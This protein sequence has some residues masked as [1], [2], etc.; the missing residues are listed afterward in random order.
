MLL[1]CYYGNYGNMVDVGCQKMQR[2][3]QGLVNHGDHLFLSNWVYRGTKAL[4]HLPVTR[5]VSH[6]IITCVTLLMLL[7]SCLQT[8]I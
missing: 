7:L 1:Q 8:A 5:E 3:Q 6:D 4:P 2:L